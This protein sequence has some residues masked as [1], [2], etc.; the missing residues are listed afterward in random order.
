MFKRYLKQILA[1]ISSR[2][3]LDTSLFSAYDIDL[4]KNIR[5]RRI[6]YLTETR[7]G[8]IVSTINTIKEK[9]IEGV[10]IEAGCALGGSTVLIAKCK[11]KTVPLYVYDVFGLIPA[12]TES[13][14]KEVH[15]RYKVIVSGRSKGIGGNEYYGYQKDLY[16][17]VIQNLKS[18]E[19]DC[20]GDSITLIKGILQET[21]KI[22]QSVSF[23]HIDVDWYEPVKFCLENIFPK[24]TVGGSLI[25]DDYYDW[26]GCKKAVD[27]YLQTVTGQFVL[28]GAA[29][30][31]KITRISIR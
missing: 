21:M 10:F 19:L 23:A 14:G 5:A 8:S 7:L 28:D 2:R 29:G 11:D 6:T 4:I 13:D 16:K 12:P 3:K 17:T 31:L 22:E 25:F 1:K 18:F 20:Q 26:S 30:S 27:G 9:G 15:E 24:L